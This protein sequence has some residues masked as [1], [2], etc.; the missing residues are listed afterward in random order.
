MEQKKADP[1]VKKVLATSFV[2]DVIE[3]AVGN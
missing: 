3:E 2:V 1:R